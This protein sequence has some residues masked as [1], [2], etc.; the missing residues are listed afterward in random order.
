MHLSDPSR[1]RQ[2]IRHRHH[3]FPGNLIVEIPKGSGRVLLR[4][5]RLG[6]I[7]YVV[8]KL[9]DILEVPLL[10]AHISIPFWG[11]FCSLEVE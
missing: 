3:P 10:E 1:F 2:H 9:G 4:I 11:T 6:W 7:C 8:A 5:C